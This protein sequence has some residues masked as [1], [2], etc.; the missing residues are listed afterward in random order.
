[1]AGKKD[2]VKD[3][4]RYSIIT[5]KLDRCFVCGTTQGVQM[6]EIFHG[7]NRSKSKDDGMCIP[8]CYEH[9]HGSNYGIHYNSEL[10]L[11]VKKLA[12]KIWLENYTDKEDEY[13]NRIKLFIKRYGKNYLDEEDI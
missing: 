12:E 13:N 6:H 2:K 7:S 5:E 8:L 1:M 11:K 3:K 4:D 9:H 10:E